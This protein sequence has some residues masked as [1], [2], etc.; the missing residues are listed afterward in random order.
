MRSRPLVSLA[1]V[2]ASLAATSACSAVQ[3]DTSAGS[4]PAKTINFVTVF[5]ANSP[6][7]HLCRTSFIINSGAVEGLTT[8]DTTTQEL[9]PALA[10]TWET[11]DGK[12]WTF[13]IR[14]GVTFHN[15]KPVT[16]EAVKK[17]LDA[18][19]QKN[20]G[21]KLALGGATITAQGQKV[22]MVSD[23]VNASLPSEL[24]HYNAVITDVDD[25]GTVPVGTGPF[26]FTSF[27]IDGEAKL[28]RFDGYWGGPAKVEHIT[29]TAND[30]ANARML[31]LRSGA[32]NVIHQPSIESL[33]TLR[34]DPSIKVD[35][36]Q[37]TRVYHLLYNFAGTNA[38]L[39]KNEEFR[40]GIDALVDREQI[41]KTVLHGEGVA[42]DNPFPPAY[43][44]A[45]KPAPREFGKEAALAHFAKAGLKVDGGTVTRNG[46][47]LQLRLGTYIA[48]PELPQIAQVVQAAAGQVGIKVDIDTADNIDEY[49]PK[50][51][52]DLATYSIA[53]VTRGDASYYLKGGLTPGGAQNH[54]KLDDP[55]LNR[56][57]GTYQQTLD[58]AKR[59]AMTQEIGAYMRDKAY[60]SYIVAPKATAAYNT[61]VTGWVTPASEFD[62]PMMTTKIDVG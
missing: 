1:L 26:R 13:D 41:T 5:A 58:P 21:V 61:K 3:D 11:R 18:A 27:D 36:A 4:T 52:W 54:G 28:D 10:T 60:N 39:W 55:W 45:P 22:T 59:S 44:L 56:T 17:S 43:P 19:M 25:G 38:A 48:R 31:A 62:G 23:K 57:I 8:V 9:T 16:G 53:T 46:A 24:A 35:T 15:G 47:P 20:P 42:L 33:A 6:D 32:A 51:Q 7:P 50:G 40:R 30:D 14:E 12:T 29:M 2:V 49:L 37:G 34:Q